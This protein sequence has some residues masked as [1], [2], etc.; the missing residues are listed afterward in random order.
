[1]RSLSAARSPLSAGPRRRRKLIWIG[2]SLLILG[3][4][5]VAA[6][7]YAIYAAK[8]DLAE[9]I[10]ATDRSDPGWRLEDLEASRRVVPDEENSAPLVEAAGKLLGPV[11]KA[12]GLPKE[13]QLNARSLTRLRSDLR[14]VSGAVQRARQL[15]DRPWGRFAF[16]WDLFTADLKHVDTCRQVAALL[17]ADAMLRAQDLDLDGAA[18]S[19]RALINVARALG[20]EPGI[21]AG[22]VRVAIGAIAVEAV[23]RTLAQGEPSEPAL[24]SLQ[25]L[26]KLEDQEPLIFN[27]LRGERA[28]GDRTM[29]FLEE[30]S[31]QWEG[32]PGFDLGSLGRWG[33]GSFTVNRV[34]A[35]AL[36]GSVPRGH[37]A[38]LRYYNR[39]V[40]ITRL[41][42]AEQQER[43]AAL[44]QE[45]KAQVAIPLNLRMAFVNL[46]APAMSKICEAL[47]RHRA[48]V[49][50][51][52]VAIATERYR[53]QHGRWPDSLQELVPALI[54]AIPFDP[55]DASP[56]HYRRLDDGL[57]IY[58]VG[59]DGQ[60][61]GGN[62]FANPYTPGADI[63]FRLWNAPAR[64]Q[65]PR[66]ADRLD[67]EP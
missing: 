5:V 48:Q 47:R 25:E 20:D 42:E 38:L 39:I 8:R 53:R 13:V 19:C 43:F 37:A 6:Y 51:A 44:E 2:G 23:E 56:L 46:L 29:R 15:K 61:N 59:P 41:P 33:A 54:I 10:A 18:D 60:D 65:P 66:S 34:A 52:F 12:A 67:S 3:G 64:R 26:L 55:Y 1:M 22:L 11:P 21:I 16:R 14:Q 45:V 7:F 28:I 27:L 24:E 62:L 36:A 35:R 50:S 32:L 40:E 57:A 63:G 17:R 30:N 4:L 31:S 9:A 49:R 58:S